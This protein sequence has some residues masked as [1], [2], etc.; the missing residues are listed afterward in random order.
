MLAK[1]VIVVLLL[2]ILGALM[3]SMLFLVRDG[4]ERKRTLTGLK[5]RVALSVT[6]ILFL[7]LAYHQGWIHP[8][9]I[10]PGANEQTSTP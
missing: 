8:H 7:M 10:Y 5:I 2:A 1:I 4:S 9:G 3:T 6:L